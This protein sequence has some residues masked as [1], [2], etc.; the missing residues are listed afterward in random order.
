VSNGIFS[1]GA[2]LLVLTVIVAVDTQSWRVMALGFVGSMTCYGLLWHVV[3]LR[4]TS[5]EQAAS[6][7]KLS[8]GMLIITGL[9][10]LFN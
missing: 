5:A 7:R 1:V 6:A 3:S 10:A 8:W 2:L 9:A 4:P